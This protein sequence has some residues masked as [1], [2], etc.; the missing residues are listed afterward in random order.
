M[1]YMRSITSIT[2]FVLLFIAS[3]IGENI[4]NCLHLILVLLNAI[5]VDVGGCKVQTT[6]AFG[7][8]IN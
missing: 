8:L 6:D 4:F 3:I 2:T 7:M 1:K 5:G